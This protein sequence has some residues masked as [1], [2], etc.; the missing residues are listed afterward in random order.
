MFS[1]TRCMLNC[2]KNAIIMSLF[3]ITHAT[4]SLKCDQ[5]VHSHLQHLIQHECVSFGKNLPAKQAKIHHPGGKIYQLLASRR[6][7]SHPLV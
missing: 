7:L 1:N 6:M 3:C 4:S 2:N 5:K